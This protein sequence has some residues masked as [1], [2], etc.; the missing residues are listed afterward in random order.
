MAAAYMRAH[1]GHRGRI[2]APTFG[3]AVEAC[4]AGPSG[5]QAIDPQVRWLPTAPGGAKVSWP[6]GSQALVLGTPFPRRY[7]SYS[8]G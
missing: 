3:D 4:I 5:L 8:N 7:S 2:I 6:N 1:P